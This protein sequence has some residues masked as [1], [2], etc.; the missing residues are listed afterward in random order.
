MGNRFK[1]VVSK[2][3]GRMENEIEQHMQCY[4]RHLQCC[5]RHLVQDVRGRG[6]IA[7]NKAKRSTIVFLADG[8]SQ[9]Y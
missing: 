1:G 8:F 2:D 9:M 4:A 5:Y 7:R 3:S 6:F